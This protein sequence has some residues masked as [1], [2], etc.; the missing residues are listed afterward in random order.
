MGIGLPDLCQFRA[1]GGNR[2]GT[3]G[4]GTE[5]AETCMAEVGQSI[6][7]LVILE[8][9]AVVLRSM[10]EEFHARKKIM[11]DWNKCFLVNSISFD[12]TM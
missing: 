2:P 11:I 9:V 4:V 6:I 8:A 5:S 1:Y 10:I 7:P 3:A 12:G